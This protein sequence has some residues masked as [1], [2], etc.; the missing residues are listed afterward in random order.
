MRAGDKTKRAEALEIIEFSAKHG[1]THNK[2]T[3]WR[4]VNQF[5]AHAEAVRKSLS[6]FPQAW[7]SGERRF[8]EKRQLSLSFKK[9]T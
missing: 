4:L 8:T 6:G 2:E 3:I 1:I 9:N 5:E 7:T